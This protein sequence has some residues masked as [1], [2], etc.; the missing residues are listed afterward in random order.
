MST[1]TSPFPSMC[2]DRGLASLG[3]RAPAL[4]SHVGSGRCSLDHP[5]GVRSSPNT[6]FLS[7]GVLKLNGGTKQRSPEAPQ[8]DSAHRIVPGWRGWL[9]PRVAGWCWKKDCKQ[10][11]LSKYRCFLVIF[12]CI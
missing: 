11:R 1:F 12:I 6:W 3:E 10:A 2:I 5:N 7:I 4:C 9:V 8:D